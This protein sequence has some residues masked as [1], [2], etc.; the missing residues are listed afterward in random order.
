MISPTGSGSAG[1]LHAGRRPSRRCSCGERQAVDRRRVELLLARGLDVA[2]VRV[3]QRLR[4]RA[5]SPAPIAV[6]ARFLVAGVG[7]RH[8]RATRARACAADAVHV[9]LD[10]HARE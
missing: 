8:Q 3:E 2:R 7:L 5:R 9:G 4:R 10:V 6:S 1:D